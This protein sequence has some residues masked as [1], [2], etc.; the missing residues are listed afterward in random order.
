MGSPGCLLADHSLAQ[1][2]DSVAA[3]TAAP[4]GGTAAALAGAVAAALVEMAA[5]FTLTREDGGERSARSDGAIGRMQRLRE[6]LTGLAERELHAY[7]PVLEARRLPREHPDRAGRLREA[8]SVAADSPVAIARATAEIAELG[9]ELSRT[10]NEHLV[11]DAI[12]GA[13]LAE[14]ACRAATRLAEINLAHEAQDPR[15]TD[16]AGLARRAA[17]ARIQA[18]DG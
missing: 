12:T 10:G 11:G 3:R 16:V 9:A 17:A 1:V 18:L 6:Q 5:K 13:L 4:G 2:L 14:A 15:L 7:E 8:L